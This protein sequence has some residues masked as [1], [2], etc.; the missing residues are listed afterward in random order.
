MPEQDGKQT[1]S[2]LRRVTNAPI[3]V[4]SALDGKDMIVDLLNSGSD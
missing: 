1:L 4:V 3:I 2:Q